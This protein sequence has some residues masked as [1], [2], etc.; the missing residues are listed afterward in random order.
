MLAWLT[1]V[2]HR[3]TAFRT[4]G[5]IEIV[6]EPSQ[7]PGVTTGLRDVYYPGAYAVSQSRRS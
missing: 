5:M 2:C 1:E 3:W 4:V 7:D 6:N